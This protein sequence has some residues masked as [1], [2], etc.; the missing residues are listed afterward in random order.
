MDSSGIHRQSVHPP[1]IHTHNAHAR[2]HGKETVSWDRIRDRREGNGKGGE[3]H[4][5][6]QWQ[7]KLHKRKGPITENAKGQELK[8]IRSAAR[9]AWA[10]PF[11][12]LGGG[13]FFDSGRGEGEQGGR[14]TRSMLWVAFMAWST[15]RGLRCGRVCHMLSEP[16]WLNVYIDDEIVGGAWWHG[17]GC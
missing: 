13:V 9:A 7:A 1:T 4:Q 3:S 16:S 14:N 2:M 10:P 6:A 8:R 12:G 15:V 11:F 17:F 5:K